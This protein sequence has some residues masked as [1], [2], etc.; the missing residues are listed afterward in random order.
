[1]QEIRCKKCSSNNHVKS[2]YI[3][4]NQR[5]KCKGCGCNFKIGDNRG[6]V[7]CLPNR[8]RHVFGIGI[9][10]GIYFKNIFGLYT[11]ALG[12]QFSYFP[13]MTN[14]YYTARVGVEFKF[15][16]KKHKEIMQG[17]ELVPSY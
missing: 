9:G 12:G 10:G 14:C 13:K 6:K 1:M 5:Y 4:D 8:Y 16:S 17:L 3:R 7:H 15:Y 11:E 2:G